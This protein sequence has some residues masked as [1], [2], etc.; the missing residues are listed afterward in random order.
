MRA[1]RDDVLVVAADI[2]RRR[3][4]DAAAVDAAFDR[5][6]KVDLV[7]H[8]AARIDAAAFGSAA[9]TG[10]VGRRGAAV[11]EARAASST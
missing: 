9:D 8:G 10:A 4:A 11:A 2:E 3:A 6:G 5:F 7:V 1:E